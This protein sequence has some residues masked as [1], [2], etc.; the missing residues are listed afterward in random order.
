MDKKEV[1]GRPIHVELSR[2]EAEKPTLFV[3]RPQKCIQVLD[4]WGAGMVVIF[5]AAICGFCFIWSLTLGMDKSLDRCLALSSPQE[6]LIK[7]TQVVFDSPFNAIQIYY[8][9]SS[10]ASLVDGFARI[11]TTDLN[12]YSKW[13][14]AI[15]TNSTYTCYLEDKNANFY[16]LSMKSCTPAFVSY[17]AIASFFGLI[18]IM[19]V[20]FR[21][22]RRIQQC[23]KQQ[24][25]PSV[26][27]IEVK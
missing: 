4:S 12:V 14:T 15:T 26:S 7:A 27:F 2:Y 5:F 1:G 10:P 9:V 25:M 24:L 6:C 23:Q 8:S 19:F 11:N 22:V 20:I 16:I 18:V 13:I 17:T 21:I 3:T